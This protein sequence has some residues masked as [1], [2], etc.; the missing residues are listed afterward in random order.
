MQIYLPIAELPVNVLLML[1]LGGA[2]GFLSG[3]FGVGGG[4]LMTPLLIF[5]GV[6]S[7]VAVATGA[8]PLIA[9][10]ITGTIAQAR[11][12]N[13]DTK[14]G[15]FL[16][17]GG[18]VGA[19]GGVLIIRYLRQIGQVDLFVSLLYVVFM[20]AVGS[21]MLV[22]SLRA[23]RKVRRGQPSAKRTGRHGWLHGLPF[24]TRFPASKLYISAIPPVLA[25]VLVGVMSGVMGVGGGFILVPILIYLLHVPTNV[26]VG[27]S[28][29]QIIFVS[30]ITTVLQAAM[31]QTVDIALAL[32]LMLGGAF[33]AQV[34]AAAGQKLRAEE[35]RLL[36]ALLVLAV[37]LRL[38]VNLVMPGEIF[39]VTSAGF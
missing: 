19:F 32:L 35:L 26:A 7:A 25:G 27:T 9:S 17:G 8:N 33:G 24:K 10:S 36:L 23:L 37:G 6:P 1:G 14:L 29:F 16:L 21:M 20:G 5:A 15:L 3:M 13:L 18:A 2:V 38:G 28:L 30:A 31:N 22:E 34:G 39:S 11:R 4:F 12:K